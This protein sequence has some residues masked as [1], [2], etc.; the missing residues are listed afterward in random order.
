MTSKLQN[1][2]IQKISNQVASL[3]TILLY[4]YAALLL[5]QPHHHV[6]FFRFCFFALFNSTSAFSMFFRLQKCLIARFVTIR[7]L[8][9]EAERLFSLVSCQNAHL[10]YWIQGFHSILVKENMARRLYSWLY[11]TDFDFWVV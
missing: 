1:P 3:Q 4:I 11:K 10:M 5:T 2:V 9:Y 8:A 7:L 6:F